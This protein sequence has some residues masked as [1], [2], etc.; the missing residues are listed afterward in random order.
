MYQGRW[1]ESE[2]L[3]V[4]VIE[5]TKRLLVEEHSSTPTSISNLAL[6]LKGQ[7]H[8]RKAMVLIERCVQLQEKVLGPEHPHTKSSHSTLNQ[9]RLENTDVVD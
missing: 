6:T 1:N 5:A 7:G 3:Q 9:W 4:Q 2:A 8:H